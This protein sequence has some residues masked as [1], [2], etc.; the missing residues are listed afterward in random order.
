MQ[1]VPIERIGFREPALDGDEL[2]GVALEGDKE[3]ASVDLAGARFRQFGERVA[4]AQDAC[5]GVFLGTREADV[6]VDGDQRLPGAASFEID[7]V[8]LV[9][10]SERGAG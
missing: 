2:L 1:D 5:A 8:E 9:G 7:L 3:E 6:G 4:A 10:A